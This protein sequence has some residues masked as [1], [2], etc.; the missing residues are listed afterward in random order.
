MNNV[1]ELEIKKFEALAARWWDPTS[2]FKP[3]HEINPLR[4]GFSDLENDA[5]RKKGVGHWLR[6]RHSRRGNGEARCRSGRDRH[7]RGFTLRRPPAPV[8][9]QTRHRLPSDTGRGIGSNAEPEQY[10]IVTCLEMLEHVPDPS[11]I[12]AACHSLW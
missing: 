1:D 10:D 9:E 2:E 7:G 8:R 4:M 12:V 3:L 5:C 11:A 6:W